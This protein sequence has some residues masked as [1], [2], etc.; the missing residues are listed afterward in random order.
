VVELLR[1]QTKPL[2]QPV[3]GRI[4]PGNAGFMHL[5]TGRLSNN[6]QSLLIYAPAKQDEVRMAGYQRTRGYS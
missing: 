5:S 3:A 6:A 1:R 2:A 4:V